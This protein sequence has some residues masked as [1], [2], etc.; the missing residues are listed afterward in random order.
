MAKRHD[1]ASMRHLRGKGLHPRNSCRK[2]TLLR[3]TKLI[4]KADSAPFSRSASECTAATAQ[5]RAVGATRPVLPLFPGDAFHV[6][7]IST[8]LGQHV[9]QIIANA[10]EREAFLQKLAHA[11]CA[12]QK[13]AQDYIVLARMTR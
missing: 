9:V 1:S 12:K 5:R 6:L 2:P 3:A 8:G 13:E 10:D 4:V 7:H 11:R